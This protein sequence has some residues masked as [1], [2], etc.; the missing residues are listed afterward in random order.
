MPHT[1]RRLLRA[2]VEP[3]PED[4]PFRGPLRRIV[5]VMKRH[6]DTCLSAQARSRAVQRSHLHH[7]HHPGRSRVPACRPPSCLCGRIRPV[8]GGRARDADVHRGRCRRKALGA[9]PGQPPTRTS[10]RSGT[11]IRNARKRSLDWHARFQRDADALAAASGLDEVKRLLAKMLGDE[12]AGTVLKEYT[13]RVNAN[14][15]IG[16]AHA[17]KIDDRGARRG[18]VDC[19]QQQ[20]APTRSS[21][22][23]ERVTPHR[24][25]HSR[26]SLP[27]CAGKTRTGPAA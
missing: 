11:C 15:G 6:R 20:S 2:D 25:L 23:N 16:W 27:T 9:E 13:D 8:A 1:C 19:C 7:H 24:R 22:A 3:L 21:G 4:V 18:G 26:C 10:R 14:R 17:R 5:Q 12:T